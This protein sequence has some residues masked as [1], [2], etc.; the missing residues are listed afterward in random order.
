M[1][2]YMEDRRKPIMPINLKNGYMTLVAIW[3]Q[4]TEVSNVN[5]YG[6]NDNVTISYRKGIIIFYQNRILWKPILRT[7]V[8][9]YKAQPYVF[10]SGS[11]IRAWKR[12]YVVWL[13]FIRPPKRSVCNYNCPILYLSLN[14]SN[15]KQ[16]VNK[17][18]LFTYVS[19]N[20]V[21]SI[22]QNWNDRKM[23]CS[24]LSRGTNQIANYSN[25]Q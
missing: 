22:S 24:R 21:S 16:L 20:L 12:F 18:L 14:K 9:L 5:N 13:L 7:R 3:N 4:V 10:Q 2:T 19:L 1:G 8:Q 11:D 15:E 17:M 25:K 23:R 6:M